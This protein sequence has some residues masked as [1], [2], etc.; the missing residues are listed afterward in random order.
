MPANHKKH[1]QI[2]LGF[3]ITLYTVILAQLRRKLYKNRNKESTSE[4]QSRRYHKTH[5]SVKQ[6]IWLLNDV[7]MYR[8][9]GTRSGAL[10]S[11]C[12]EQVMFNIICH[13]LL[14][15]DDI[16]HWT[17]K[18]YPQ[19]ASLG[20]VHRDWIQQPLHTRLAV[21][22]SRPLRLD[23]QSRSCRIGRLYEWYNEQIQL[24]NHRS[25]DALKQ[26][27]V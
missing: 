23:C 26:C 8:Y 11:G 2:L 3:K 14:R 20:Y 19:S 18:T 9:V 7:R 25:R 5:Q 24:V 10:I 1:Q 15:I 16:C 6:F 12:T 13:L 22:S 4:Q 21:M 17:S 27:Q